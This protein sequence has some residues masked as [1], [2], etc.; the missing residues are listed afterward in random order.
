MLVHSKADSL[1]GDRG[2]EEAEG[3]LLAELGQEVCQAA[4]NSL[5]YLW[6]S[7]RNSPMPNWCRAWVKWLKASPW[8]HWTSVQRQAR[9]VA[10]FV[11]GCR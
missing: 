7:T 5:R 2:S 1:M 10:I 6:R 8:T 4:A 9:S 11:I 3:V